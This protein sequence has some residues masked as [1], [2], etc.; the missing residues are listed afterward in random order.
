MYFTILFSSNPRTTKNVLHIYNYLFYFNLFFPKRPDQ[1]F[2]E[3]IKDE[4]SEDFQKRYILKRENSSL[5]KDD[6]Q[7]NMEHYSILTACLYCA[8][9]I[10]N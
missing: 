10:G 5:D 2:C 8:M 1:K 6:N 9:E 3:H 4:K 7:V